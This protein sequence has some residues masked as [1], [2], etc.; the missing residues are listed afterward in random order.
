MK[1]TVEVGM[2]RTGV[3][4][5]PID[6]K[7]MVE[8][9]KQTVPSG[10]GDGTAIHAVRESYAKDAEPVGTVPIPGSATGVA[11][12]VKT[13]I[14]GDKP[15]VLLDK[16]GERLAFERMGT[17]LYESLISKLESGGSWQGGPTRQDLARIHDD[18][19]RHFQQLRDAIVRL[20]ADPTSITP[21]ADVASVEATGL[22]QVVTDPRTTM[23]QALQAILIAEL[24][25]AEG[26]AMLVQLAQA[27]GETA[28]ADEAKKA[29]RE[30]ETHLGAVRAWLTQQVIDEAK[31][32][33]KPAPAE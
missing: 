1:N 17:R 11:Q 32:A 8:G 13:A 10:T 20:G 2:N 6:G 12:T 23:P 3:D 14:K 29:A 22:L 4:M 33:L 24:A 15:T 9:A 7:A 18:E 28:L 25:D 21:C 19:L 26:W 5:S 27:V 16:L 31:R 30:E